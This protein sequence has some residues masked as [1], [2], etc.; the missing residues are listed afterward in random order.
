MQGE[1][2]KIG[3]CI[4]E[5]SDSDKCLGVIV[6]NQLNRNSQCDVVAIGSN[7]ILGCINK[8]ISNTNKEG[9]ILHLYC[10]GESTSGTLYLVLGIHTADRMLKI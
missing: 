3:D 9:I 10:T 6:A 2:Y 1:T 4:P 5:S 7:E 8:E